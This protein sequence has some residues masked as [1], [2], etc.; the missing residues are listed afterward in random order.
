[1]VKTRTTFGIF[2]LLILVFIAC[3]K[4]PNLTA[5]NVLLKAPKGFPEIIQPSDNLFTLER[6]SL[7]KRLFFDKRL[8]KNNKVSCATCHHPK[9]AFS[10]TT[11]FSIGDSNKFGT[12]NAPSLTNIGYQPY[13][14][15]AGG[16][17]SL[18]MQIL[19]PI[20]EH[21][22]FNSSMLAIIEKLSQDSSY[23]KAAQKSYGRP[24][25]PFVL[26]RALANFERS[27]ISGNSIYDQHFIENKKT[28]ILENAIRGKALFF[29]NKTNCSN[30]HNGFNFTN[31]QFENNG[32]YKVYNNI[33]RMR[34]T[35]L[36]TDRARFKTPTLRN[37]A[38][39]A[40][41]MHDGSFATLEDVVRHY[42]SGG[43]LHP[44]KSKLIRP[45]SLG[46]D[47]ISDLVSFLRTLTDQEFI[48]NKKFTP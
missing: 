2:L 47:E 19:I 24:F 10:D 3:N 23:Q 13:F 45:L 12:S 36:E 8:S 44:N 17:P 38:K 48:N 28:S 18:E 6:W 9:N 22:E 41:Y 25:D 39:T 21:N 5:E 26:V 33:G 20:Q 14:T 1:M 31:Y 11:R 43:E 4:D 15:R 40:P 16:S 42:N 37:I 34:L 30:C 46:N 7:G 29:S 27:F 35:F 32:L